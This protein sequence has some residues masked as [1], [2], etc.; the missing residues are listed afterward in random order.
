M[1]STRGARSRL[2]RPGLVDLNLNSK[3]PATEGFLGLELYRAILQGDDD[4]LLHGRV[5]GSNLPPYHPLR[6]GAMS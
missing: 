5:R 2:E 6:A 3:A 4:E 1:A